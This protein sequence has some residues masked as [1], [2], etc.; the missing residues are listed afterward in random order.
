MQPFAV[1]LPL[2]LLWLC[3]PLLAARTPPPP[4]STSASAAS[5][6]AAAAMPE[7]DIEQLLGEC[8]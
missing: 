2:A 1:F 5:S 8:Y 3:V 6:S 7:F 4:V